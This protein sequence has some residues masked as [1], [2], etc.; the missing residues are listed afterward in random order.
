M[1]PAVSVGSSRAARLACLD[2][3]YPAKVAEPVVRAREVVKAYGNGGAARRV[4]EGAS[5]E[6]GAGEL[7]AVVGRSG[8]GKSTLLHLLGGLDRPDSGTIE[9]AGVR[10]DGRDER[11]L[12]ELRRRRVGFVFQAF[13]LLPE[14]T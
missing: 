2:G 7:V 4:L 13:H 9:G 12:T 3:F 10:V 1:R 8:T 11:A 14:L 5:L 6:V